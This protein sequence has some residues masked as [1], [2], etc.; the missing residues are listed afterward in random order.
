[1]ANCHIFCID[2]FLLNFIVVEFECKHESGEVAYDLIFILCIAPL[3][4]ATWI[5]KSIHKQNTW[6]KRISYRKTEW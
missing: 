4:V 1:M 3:R 2:E 6:G 5:Y